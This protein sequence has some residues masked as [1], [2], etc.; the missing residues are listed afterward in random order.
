ML[1]G[2]ETGSACTDL[3]TIPAHRTGTLLPGM[4]RRRHINPRGFPA[5]DQGKSSFHTTRNALVLL[6][7]F[8]RVRVASQWSDSPMLPGSI[9]MCMQADG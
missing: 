2:G 8:P 5:G 1:S 9:L 7:F 6:L 4:G 3:S